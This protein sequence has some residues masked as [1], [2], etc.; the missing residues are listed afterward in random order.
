MKNWNYVK[1][2]LPS[3]SGYYEI[4]FDEGDTSIGRFNKRWLGRSY[5][6]DEKF[7]GRVVVGWR[8]TEREI[9]RVR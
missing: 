7:G 3:R 8:K 4:M 2:K 1:T 5:W 6:S 9:K